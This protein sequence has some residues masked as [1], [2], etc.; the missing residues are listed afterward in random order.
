MPTIVATSAGACHNARRVTGGVHSITAADAANC[1]ARLSAGVRQQ[2]MRLFVLG[3]LVAVLS[4]CPFSVNKLNR[5]P[6]SQPLAQPVLFNQ[7]GP[8]LHAP[9]GLAFAEA[10]GSFQ[11]VTAY[12]YDTAGLDVGIGYNDSKPGC[13][14]VATFYVYPT[15]RMS[16][17]GAS[18]DVV[19]SVEL[20]W[21]QREYARSEAEIEQNHPNMQ[22]RVEG[23]AAT[24]AQGTILQGRSMIFEENGNMSELR[25]FVFDHKWFLKYRFTYPKSCEMEASKSVEGLVSRL[26]WA[27]V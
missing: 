9:S 20:G 18:P 3:I 26:P 24:L 4:G 7:P 14:I 17:I 5:L 13:L 11:R 27:A 23:P 19:S 1:A 21:L 22:S 6:A 15:P 10:Y 25:L 2:T 8:L 12:R 16:F